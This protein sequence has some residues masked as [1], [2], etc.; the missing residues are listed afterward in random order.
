MS[1]SYDAEGRRV[2]KTVQGGTTTQY[3]CDN[4]NTVQETQGSN[5]N[6]ILIGE[7][8][9]ERFAR[10]DV[11]G[12]TYFTRLHIFAD[13]CRSSTQTKS[14]K[15]RPGLFAIQFISPILFADRNVRLRIQ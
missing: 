9:D 8:V 2:A 7:G 5:V 15:P 13:G 14:P 11:T 4:L 12:R 1:Y 3:L 10:S 6:A